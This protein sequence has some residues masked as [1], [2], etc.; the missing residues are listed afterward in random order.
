[1]SEAL[2]GRV[3]DIVDAPPASEL[4]RKAEEEFNMWQRRVATAVGQVAD[5]ERRAKEEI[6]KLKQKLGAATAD[7]R[8]QIEAQIAQLEAQGAQAKAQVGAA[9]FLNVGMSYAAA[10]L[11]LQKYLDRLPEIPTDLVQD[12]A[13]AW[14]V[15]A[16]D[17][18]GLLYASVIEPIGKSILELLGEGAEWARDAF[19]AVGAFSE[20]LGPKAKAIKFVIELAVALVQIL[21]E[22]A[23]DAPREANWFYRAWA[24]QRDR[25]C[26]LMQLAGEDISGNYLPGARLAWEDRFFQFRSIQ[27]FN[28]GVFWGDPGLIAPIDRSPL[29]WMLNRTTQVY[30][31]QVFTAS[32]WGD[33]L[34]D[35]RIAHDMRDW[36]ERISRDRYRQDTDGNIITDPA[37]GW[38]ILSGYGTHGTTQMMSRGGA[39]VPVPG[40]YAAGMPWPEIPAAWIKYIPE[41]QLA[42]WMLPQ[43]GADELE[44]ALQIRWNLRQH[45]ARFGTTPGRPDERPI[46]KPGSWGP[47]R[48][49]DGV[50]KLQDAQYVQDALMVGNNPP[51]FLRWPGNPDDDE[52]PPPSSDGYE[53]ILQDIIS[54]VGGYKHVTTQRRVRAQANPQILAAIAQVKAIRAGDRLAADAVA[55]LATAESTDEN[56]VK[57]G[58][59]NTALY[60]SGRPGDTEGG[61]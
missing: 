41:V 61:P 27:T 38:P 37:T 15:E 9:A 56:M 52:A 10:E 12:L 11:G 47:V 25:W 30:I 20:Q 35:D 59:I 1:M 51:L 28:T 6:N 57:L 14:G 17:L 42:C 26:T 54:H 4:G 16:Q 33:R 40:G 29:Y 39:L 19:E 31:R 21:D 60:A 24:F 53:R 32:G 58:L 55:G 3:L 23:R 22:L 46:F 43:L 18:A 45:F 48:R 7:G 50:K 5:I 44:A 34:P 8:Y 13:R 49:I 2:A 36:V